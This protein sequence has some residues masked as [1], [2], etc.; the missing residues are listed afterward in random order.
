MKH[1]VT[2][3]KYGKSTDLIKEAFNEKEAIII[4]FSPT[5]ASKILLPIMKNFLDENKI[6]YTH[7]V[8]EN[9][10]KTSDKTF[11]FMS[12]NELINKDYQLG[13]DIPVYI[14]EAGYILREIFGNV[15]C[16][17]STGPNKKIDINRHN[18]V[19]EFFEKTYK[20]FKDQDILEKKHTYLDEDTI[21]NEFTLEWDHET[22]D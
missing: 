2:P 18:Y 16:I 15:K 4:G 22:K 21:L 9:L 7:I 19:Q 12:Y 8:S 6:S 3:R 1:I 5:I 14:D 11:Y 20:N 10:I 13:K 17:N